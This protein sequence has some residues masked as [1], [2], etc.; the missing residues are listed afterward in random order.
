MIVLVIASG[1]GFHST[2]AS[3]AGDDAMQPID[4][5]T[6]TPVDTLFD[7]PSG[8][9]IGKFV[10]VCRPVEPPNLALLTLETIN[11]DTDPRCQLQSQGSGAPQLCVMAGRDVKVDAKVTVIG[12]RP[13]VLAAYHDLNIAM[14]GNLILSSPSGQPSGAGA[15]DPACHASMPGGNGAL[16]SGGGAGGSFGGSGGAGGTGDGGAATAG[17]PGAPV[18]LIDR[19]IGGCKGSPGGNAGLTP[20]GLPGNGGG[21]VML[22]AANKLT[23]V[24]IVTAGGGGGLPA[25]VAGGGGGGSGGFV[26]LD[27]KSYMMVTGQVTANGGGG[28]SGGTAT[29]GLPGNDGTSSTTIAAPGG[30]ALAGGGGGSGSI[31]AQLSGTAGQDAASGGGGGGGAA[32]VILVKGAAPPP[33]GSYSP[34]LTIVP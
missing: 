1:C 17:T 21:A 18:T 28:A 9:C 4:A 23:L 26:G 16:G 22:I 15:N 29:V 6:D 34:P 14:N 25:I 3:V 30:P 11:T 24:G 12:S 8:L 27:A 2:A 13:L 10:L 31:A 33:G 7:A 20:G 5:G 32:G 19:V